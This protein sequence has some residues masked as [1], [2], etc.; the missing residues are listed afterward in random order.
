MTKPLPHIKTPFKPNI[1]DSFFYL[2][3][4]QMKQR[5]NQKIKPMLLRIKLVSLLF[6]TLLFHTPFS[7][8]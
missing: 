7:T 8:L 6:Q 3:L 5:P 2:N 4:E 1:W